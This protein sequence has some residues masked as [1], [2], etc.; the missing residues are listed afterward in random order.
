[1]PPHCFRDYFQMSK[2]FARDCC[3]EFDA[4]IMK[5]RHQQEHLR[6]PTPE[7]SVVIVK[8]HQAR[9]IVPG[10]FGSLDCVHTFWKNCPKAWQGQFQ[11]SERKEAIHC[12]GSNFGPSSLVLD[13]GVDSSRPAS[14][15]QVGFWTPINWPSVECQPLPHQLVG[16]IPWRFGVTS[17]LST[18]SK[19]HF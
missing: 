14:V 15:W 10:M 17:S 7:D 12:A 4:A 9:H 5:R 3:F 13:H 2:Q 16:K 8:L 1:M 6:M 18:G 19:T 11:G